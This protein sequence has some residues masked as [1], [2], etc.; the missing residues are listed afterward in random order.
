MTLGGYRVPVKSQL[1]CPTWVLHRDPRWFD[2][3]LRFE[4]Q[5]WLDGLAERLP[6]FAY[7]PFGGGPRI[8][9]GNHFAMME[10]VLLLGTMVRDWSFQ[11][12]PGYRPV[13]VPSI[14]LRPRHGMPGV[15]HKAASR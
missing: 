4:P 9:I 1:L 7:F 13:L 2:R 8:C 15:F 10:A 12:D 14:T 3:P 6:R 5:R 11:V